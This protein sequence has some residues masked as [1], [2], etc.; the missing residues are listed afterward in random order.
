MKTLRLGLTF[1]CSSA[2]ESKE[3]SVWVF[4]TSGASDMSLETYKKNIFPSH[5]V[6][7]P[8][9]LSLQRVTEIFICQETATWI[10]Q[11]LAYFI[12]NKSSLCQFDFTN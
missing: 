4:L 3:N 2:F 12:L 10:F 9:Q 5:W 6:Q 8:T 7:P 1:T 11:K